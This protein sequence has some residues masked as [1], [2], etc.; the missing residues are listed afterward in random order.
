MDIEGVFSRTNWSLL[1]KQ[2]Q[3]LVNA[4]LGQELSAEDMELLGKL[5]GFIDDV[6]DSAND[7][8]HYPVFRKVREKEC[9]T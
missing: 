7:H 9:T 1:R 2:K 3:V 5:L 6:Q 8:Y 4:S